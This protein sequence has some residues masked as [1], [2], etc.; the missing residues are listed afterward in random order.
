MR[1]LDNY[2]LHCMEGEWESG[3]AGS[4]PEPLATREKSNGSLKRRQAGV[5]L[6]LSLDGSNWG[7]CIGWRKESVN[8]AGVERDSGWGRAWGREG[9][10]G[11]CSGLRS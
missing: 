2:R 10:M 11:S 1:G 9:V 4:F 3:C 5:S 6:Y 8:R 7:K